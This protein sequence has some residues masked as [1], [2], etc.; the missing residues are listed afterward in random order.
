M[1]D[2]LFCKFA[3]GEIP[4]NKVYEDED[5]IVIRDINPQ[6]KNHFLAIPK[7]HFKLLSEMSENDAERLKR[8]LKKIPTLE[9]ELELKNG[10]RLVINQGDD[11]GQTVPHLHI[12]ILSG[13][14]M[15][16]QPA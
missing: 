4:V 2:C 12:H 8:I 15:G 16:W 13:Q 5:F 7:T 14:K 11:A 6:A 10:Y 1:D 3:K 9:K